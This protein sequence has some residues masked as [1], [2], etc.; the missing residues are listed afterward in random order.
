MSANTQNE[1][2]TVT[3]K[4][5]VAPKIHTA[6]TSLPSTDTYSTNYGSA[7]R[8]P[9][10]YQ[11]GHTVIHGKTND[12][13]KMRNGEYTIE[14]TTKDLSNSGS[15]LKTPDISMKNLDSVDGPTLKYVCVVLAKRISSARGNYIDPKTGAKGISRQNLASLI[16][17]VSVTD[18]N[19]VESLEGKTV[20]NAKLVNK[21][22]NKLGISSANS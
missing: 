17:G 3:S 21:I 7:I 12:T 6:T 14:K 19:E 16:P 4:P 9:V 20:Y 22:C 10:T 2:T 15:K 13:M 11:G 5:K 18:I 1:W 8:S